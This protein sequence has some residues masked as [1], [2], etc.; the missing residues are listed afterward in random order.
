MKVFITASEAL[1]V[2][3]GIL[4]AADIAYTEAK[5]AYDAEYAVYQ[6][7]EDQR[8]AHLKSLYGMLM[9]KWSNSRPWWRRQPNPRLCPDLGPRSITVYLPIS[10]SFC[11]AL[12][13]D[14]EIEFEMVIY[15][16]TRRFLINLK[17]V[18]GPL[19]TYHQLDSDRKRLRQLYE[20]LLKAQ[21]EQTT[22]VEVDDSFLSHHGIKVSSL[23]VLVFG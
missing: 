7:Q 15:K 8:R 10:D 9:E 2:V 20:L 12:I 1:D 21:R 4:E 13:Q 22:Y 23:P 3:Q 5:A 16:K 11:Q 14:P 17:T 18:P 6:N 19:A